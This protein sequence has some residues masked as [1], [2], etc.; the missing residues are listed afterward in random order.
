MLNSESLVAVLRRVRQRANA[1]FVRVYRA[2]CVLS[3]PIKK[4]VSSLFY[5]VPFFVLALDLVCGKMGREYSTV[6]E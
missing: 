2:Y 3:D 5:L 6:R 4:Q 1:Q